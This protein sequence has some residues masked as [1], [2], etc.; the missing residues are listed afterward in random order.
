MKNVL[1]FS[2]LVVLALA[3]SGCVS[4]R[5]ARTIRKEKL[6]EA[7]RCP[8]SSIPITVDGELNEPVW[9]K[10]KTI[11]LAIPVWFE[12]PISKTE[13]K[14]VYDKDFL[15]VAFKA[16]DQDIWGYL[17]ERDSST[18]SE[19]VLEIFFKT[20]PAKDPYFD[21]EINALGTVYDAYT[22]KRHFAGGGRRWAH[23]DCAGLKVASKVKGTINDVTDKD[24]FWILEVAIPFAELPTLGG[25]SPVKGANWLIS[26][27]RYDYSIYLPEG[28]ELTSCAPLSKLDFHWHEDWRNLIFD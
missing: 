11:S 6:L 26:L 7:Y 14:I 25:K 28:R 13:A 21:F 8:Y 9:E 23:W 27:A 5:S 16:Y 4:L 3:M 18:C 20:D 15:Y 22:V 19:D 2:A 10:A 12:E 17:T 24:E 1:F